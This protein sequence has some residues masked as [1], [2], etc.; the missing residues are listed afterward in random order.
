MLFELPSTSSHHL[1]TQDSRTVDTVDQGVALKLSNDVSQ[2]VAPPWGY[3]VTHH[4]QHPLPPQ[5][6]EKQTGRTK[7]PVSLRWVFGWS[8]HEVPGP[9]SSKMLASTPAKRP[10]QA[11]GE[12]LAGAPV[13]ETTHME[14]QVHSQKVRWTI[15]DLHNALLDHHRT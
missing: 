3:V 13:P 7:Q 8:L 12:T 10:R 14:K 9:S 6:K 5:K 11:T 2:H 15:L 4:V 1:R